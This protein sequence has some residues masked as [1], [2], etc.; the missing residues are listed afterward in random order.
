MQRKPPQLRTRRPHANGK[1]LSSPLAVA[2]W[3]RPGTFRLNRHSPDS[4]RVGADPPSLEGSAATKF[5]RTNS[6]GSQTAGLPAGEARKRPLF[7]DQC[8]PLASFVASAPS[9]SCGRGRCAQPGDQRQ[10]V[11][12]HLPR[13]RDLGHLEGDVAAMADDLRTDLDQLLAQ[14]GQRPRFC[15]LRHRQRPHEVAEIVG[16][17]MELK[18]NRVGSESAARQP[19]PLDRVLAF[20][21][22]LLARAALVIEG[23][24]ALGRPRQIGDDEADPRIKLTGVPL[25]LGHHS[26][27]LAP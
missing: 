13:H 4:R 25:D 8:T 23:D 18:S 17:S 16:K 2:S 9:S 5:D 21:D 27:G 26:P 19:G 20:L 6:V 14:A 15:G 10:D 11:G 7:R 22:V 3:S 1:R 24:D 12:E